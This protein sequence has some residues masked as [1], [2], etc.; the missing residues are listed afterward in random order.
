VVSV[1]C[2]A[3][4]L[5]AAISGSSA[6][7]TLNLATGCTYV[8]VSALPVISHDLTIGGDDATLQR[9]FASG[10]PAFTMLS[11]TGGVLT[12]T[13]L[14]F[15]HGAGAAP[16]S[17]SMRPGLEAAASSTRGAGSRFRRNDG[18]QLGGLR[19]SAR[20]L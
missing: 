11:A 14:S 2:T 17:L 18:D 6:G 9:S 16:R 10:T 8:L 1:P 12:I 3:P 13:D 20:Q 5:R 15:I 4:A 7:D 19:Q